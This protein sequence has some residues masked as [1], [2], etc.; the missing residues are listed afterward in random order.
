MQGIDFIFSCGILYVS[1]IALPS[2]QGL[3]G[4]IF[5]AT[6]QIGTAFGLTIMT[7]IQTSVTRR[8]V[9][10]LGGIYDPNHFEVPD[11]AKLKG[12]QAA[13]LGCAGFALASECSIH[14]L[15]F[16]KEL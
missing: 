14:L 8:E 6:T 10:R 9:E 13:L 15:R 7:I 16:Q 11:E 2:E 5:N 1:L 3:A 12:L 4:G